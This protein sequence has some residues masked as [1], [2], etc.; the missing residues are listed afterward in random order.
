MAEYG[1]FRDEHCIASG[2]RSSTAAWREVA[3]RAEAV[4]LAVSPIC[5]DH[6]GQS[7]DWCQECFFIEESKE[8]MISEA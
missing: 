1:I 8:R 3:R 4:E 7:A 2:F 5:L 6:P